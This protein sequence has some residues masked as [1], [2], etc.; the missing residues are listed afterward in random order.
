MILRRASL[1]FVGVAA[2][3]VPQG[4]VP[5]F[6]DYPARD[7]LRVAPVAPDLTNP[8][9]QRF[10]TVLRRGAAK[11]LNFAGGLTIVVWGC[12][13][14]CQSGAIIDGR[15]GKVSPLPQSLVRG[16]QFR[17]SSRL[18]V[19]DPVPPEPQPFESPFVVY[20]EWR[21]TIFVVIDSVRAAIKHTR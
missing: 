20:Y 8:D 15:T 16:A 2:L 9:Y 14:S 11:G 6:E 21:D 1:A 17:V 18:F 7:T 5:R 3:L 10:R 19:A 12:G 13:T 4:K